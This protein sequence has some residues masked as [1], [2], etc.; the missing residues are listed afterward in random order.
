MERTTSI[1]P[2]GRR[3]TVRRSWSTVV[4]FARR[5]AP[6]APLLAVGLMLA[7]TARIY[8]SWQGYYQKPGYEGVAAFADIG[9]ISGSHLG[10]DKLVMNNNP[11]GFDGQ[12]FYFIALDPT[13]PIICAHHPP[14][15]ALDL[16]FGEVRAE[17]V[18]YPW[19]AGLLTFGNAHLVPYT[20]LLANF[21]AIVITAWLVGVM[22]VEAGGS[23]WLGA[24][25]ALFAGEILGFLRDVAD[26]FSVM[27]VVLAVF[28]LRR[29]RYALMGLAVA[30]ALLTRE[31]LILSLPLLGLPLIVQKRWRSLAVASLIGL[32]PFFAW[33]I[34]LRIV[35]GKWALLTGDTAGAGVNTGLL[36]VPFHGLWQERH[37][38]DFG[39]IVAL[40]VV[41][42]IFAV[43]IS[44]IALW[45][46]WQA[47]RWRAALNDPVPLFVIIY[48]GMLSITSW[49][50][51][52]D[53]WTP[54]RLAAPAIALG[55][56]V[57]SELR[58]PTLR[59]SYATIL[60]LSS[61]APIMVV[62]R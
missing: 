62:I 10:L 1:L 60:F 3:E 46:N 51:W 30:G 6:F 26:P 13:Q 5:I 34:V 54:G 58:L 22:A 52:Q 21:V 39:I 45:R 17:R 14:N 4:A 53:M 56:I 48:T 2:A 43:I 27:W 61:L 33:Q 42:L 23:R 7:L 36:L 20:L 31:Q 16:A 40:V 57:A 8:F 32:V 19:I 18:L 59:T 50:L 41:P 24:A 9:T 38:A 15:C 49:L 28:F 55:V 25:A 12:F 37:R 35:W 44:A 29:Q 47:G 11:T